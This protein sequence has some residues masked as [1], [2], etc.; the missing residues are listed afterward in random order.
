MAVLVTGAVSNSLGYFVIDQLIHKKIEVVAVDDCEPQALSLPSEGC[1]Y[2]QTNF[3]KESLI[4]IVKENKIEYIIHLKNSPIFSNSIK[5]SFDQSEENITRTIAILDACT[6]TNVKKIIFPSTVAVYGEKGEPLTE[7]HELNPV[8]FEGLSKKIEEQYIKNYH[9]L[10]GINYT[11]LRYSTIYG[12]VLVNMEKKDPILF[13]LVRMM[14]SQSPLIYGSGKQQKDL[15]YIKDA[16][17]AIIASITKGD[18]E[19]F[20]IS[21]DFNLSLNEII[22]IIQFVMQ[23]HKDP[24]YDK[25]QEEEGSEGSISSSKARFILQWEPQTRLIDGIMETVKHLQKRQAFL[26]M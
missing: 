10:F 8:L 5:D 14:K 24:I 11:I 3:K 17:R 20:N 7:N 19:I 25:K 21:S 15:L 9:K 6:E 23:V 22:S 16:A 26:S 13:N 1:I 2:Y 18:N 4:N 12:S